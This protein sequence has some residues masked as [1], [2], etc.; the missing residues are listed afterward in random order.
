[1]ALKIYPHISYQQAPREVLQESFAQFQEITLSS[2]EISIKNERP[3]EV[4]V[5]QKWYQ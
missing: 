1:M 4:N 3:S 2:F 5:S